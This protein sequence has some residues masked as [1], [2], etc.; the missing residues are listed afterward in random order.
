MCNL[1]ILLSPVMVKCVDHLKIHQGSQ[2]A[3]GDSWY[4][5][6]TFSVK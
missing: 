4:D 5:K 3:M 1:E 2:Q 6:T